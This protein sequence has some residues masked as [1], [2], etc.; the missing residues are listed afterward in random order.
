MPTNFPQGLTSMGV[1]AGVGDLIPMNGRKQIWVRGVSSLATIGQNRDLIGNDGAPG[2]NPDEPLLTMARAFQLLESGAVIHF[3][4]DIKEQLSAP[5]GIFDV[6]IIG[7]GTRPR[8]ADAH[9]GN[10]GYSAATWK[11]PAV[12]AATTALLTVRQQGWRFA[13]ILFACPSDDAALDFIRDAAAG[14]LERDSSHAAVLGCRFAGAGL[15]GI[16]ISG[17]ENVFDLLIKGNIFND[18][19]TAIT[20]GAFCHRFIIEDNRFDLN[21]N[22]IVASLT[23]SFILNNVMGQFTTLS[24]DLTGGGGHNVI[25]KNYLSGTYGIGG[26]YVKSNANDE[27]AGNFNSLAG[28]ITAADPA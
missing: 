18:L 17:T 8:H 13:N 3:T 1:P 25:T 27:W 23:D 6:T 14:D 28:G 2:D 19:T 4:G 10:N 11:S 16:K 7:E 15:A 12:P 21:T 22:H 5:D 26:G 20:A 9:T 24:I